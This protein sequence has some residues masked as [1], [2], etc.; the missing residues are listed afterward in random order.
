[1]SAEEAAGRKRPRPHMPSDVTPRLSVFDRFA[2]RAAMLVSRAWFFACCVL[3]VLLWAPSVLLIG[4]IDTWQLIINTATTIVTFLLVALLQ[5]TQTRNDAATQDKLNAIAEA[6]AE[7]MTHT[8]DIHDR[9]ELR[10]SVREL[11][12]A[13]GLED[14]ESA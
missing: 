10:R 4:N 11:R 7:L 8:A 1:M 13:V 3:L 9:R 14:E 2:T 5:N 6:M 12:D